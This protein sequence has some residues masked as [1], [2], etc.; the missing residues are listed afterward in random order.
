MI[1][2]ISG[3]AD[4]AYNY[5]NRKIEER[6]SN[7]EKVTSINEYKYVSHANVI[8]GIR[9]PHGAF[10]GSWRKRK[11]IFDIVATLRTMGDTPNPALKKIWQELMIQEAKPVPGLTSVPGGWINQSMAIDQAAAMLAREIDKEV[12]EQLG[13]AFNEQ[14]NNTG[15]SKPNV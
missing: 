15:W 9:N 12:L 7:G 11:D 10:I 2:V 3:T 8:R 4:E 13:V 6:I 14:G 1:F 5:I